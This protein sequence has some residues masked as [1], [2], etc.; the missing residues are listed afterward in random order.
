VSIKYRHIGH[1]DW[2]Y[3]ITEDYSRKLLSCMCDAT[4]EILGK[5]LDGKETKYVN[6]SNGRITI[7]EG[8]TW[9]GAN[10]FPDIECTQEA[11]LVHDALYQMIRENE[12]AENWRLCADRLLY[13]VVTERSQQRW[14]ASMMYSAIRGHQQVPILGGILGGLFGLFGGLF[15]DPSFDCE[16]CD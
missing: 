6:V 10:W 9:N 16:L 14:L 1:P 8:Y 13:C 15:T 5:D 11:T 3:Q 7:C 12:T 2:K 4:G